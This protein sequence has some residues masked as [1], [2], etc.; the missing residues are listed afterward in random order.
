[1]ELKYNIWVYCFVLYLLMDE[2]ILWENWMDRAEGQQGSTCECGI[3]YAH[4]SRLVWL[5][6]LWKNCSSEFSIAF[7]P[8]T[9]GEILNEC[10][11]YYWKL[12]I[13]IACYTVILCRHE[14]SHINLLQSRVQ[15]AN[16]YTEKQ[17][18]QDIISSW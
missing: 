14:N 8:R 7:L 9:C 3:F 11:A 12:Y 13:Y 17:T 2:W 16:Y 4:I 1:V 18:T 15:P 5:A 10:S 6:N